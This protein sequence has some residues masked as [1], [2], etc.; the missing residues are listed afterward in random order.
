LGYYKCVPCTVQVIYFSVFLNVTEIFCI[1][2]APVKKNTKRPSQTL[3]S[4][5]CQGGIN[6]M[7]ETG[8]ASNKVDIPVNVK[9]AAKA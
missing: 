6:S 4:I 3:I 1:S 8:K 2:I 9:P 7:L 5:Q